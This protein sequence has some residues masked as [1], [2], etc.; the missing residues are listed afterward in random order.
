MKYQKK[1]DW[2]YKVYEDVRINL[3]KNFPYVEHELFN[4]S[5]ETMTVKK[6]YTWDGATGAV[7]TPS[8]MTP[9]L[10][11]DVLYQCIR[12]GL[13]SEIWKTDSDDLLKSMCLDRGMSSL[14]AWYVHKAVKL[15]GS[16]FIK[17]DII[18]V[19]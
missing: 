17:R 11:H 4:I 5:G 2:K 16:S 6:G 15:F 3:G 18:E 10:C 19:K 7:D 14:R 12:E 9:S 1:R 8:F 13:L